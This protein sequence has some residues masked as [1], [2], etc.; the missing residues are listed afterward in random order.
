MDTCKPA[1]EKTH[2]V[3]LEHT[4]FWVSPPAILKTIYYEPES[5]V[6]KRFWVQ[7]H[8]G[9]RTHEIQWVQETADP[10]QVIA[11]VMRQLRALPWEAVRPVDE[12]TAEKPDEPD[13]PDSVCHL[14]FG[15]HQIAVM[16]QSLIYPAMDIWEGRLSV[17]MWHP[18][19]SYTVVSFN[20]VKLRDRHQLIKAIDELPWPAWSGRARAS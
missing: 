13:N 11:A 19:C 3:V 17:Y 18:R 4:A 14:T 6:E 1:V 5:G 8:Q 16:D 20:H 7:F 9:S 10:G 15:D 12:S 2:H